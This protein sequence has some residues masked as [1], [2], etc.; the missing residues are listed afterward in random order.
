[1][2]EVQTAELVGSPNEDVKPPLLLRL[3]SW[4][5]WVYGELAP[6]PAG[7]APSCFFPLLLF[8]LVLWLLLCVQPW[9]ATWMNRH[10]PEIYGLRPVHMTVVEASRNSPQ[11]TLKLD[12][13]RRVAVEF[14]TYLNHFITADSASTELAAARENLQGCTGHVWLDEPRHTLFNVYRVWQ[15]DCDRPEG[16]LYYHQVVHGSDLAGTLVKMGLLGFVL[17][18]LLCTIWLVR[19]RRGLFSRALKD[20]E[21]GGKERTKKPPLGKRLRSWKWWIYGDMQSKPKKDIP[22]GHI[23]NVVVGSLGWILLG[24]QPWITT[25]INRVPPD[26]STLKKVHGKI[27][28]AHEKSPHVVLKTDSGTVFKFDYPGFLIVYPRASGSME[29][30]GDQNRNV[31]GCKATVWFDIPRYTLWTRHR[32]WQIACDDGRAAASYQDFLEDLDS[33]LALRW[34]GFVIFIFMPSGGMLIILRSRRGF[35]E[36]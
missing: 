5:W 9:A 3:R 18:P 8:D 23:Y 6:K 27:I 1:M 32:L 15:V 4:K 28:N 10:P 19:V 35:Y 20:G 14:P 2:N 33:R 21:A 17:V 31:L 24:V 12:D 11:L 34:W 16:S 29:K 30:L 26:F 13:G 7:P 22:N 36:R 25:W